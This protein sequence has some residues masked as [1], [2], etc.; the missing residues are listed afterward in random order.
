MFEKVTVLSKVMDEIRNSGKAPQEMLESDNFGEYME[1]LYT[2]LISDVESVMHENE[3]K[4]AK[5]EQ[6]MRERTEMHE[7]YYE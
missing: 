2:G 5:L 6:E 7:K 4:R 3:A 1:T